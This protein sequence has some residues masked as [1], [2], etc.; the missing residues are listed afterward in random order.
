MPDYPDTS[1][2]VS[3]IL[4]RKRQGPGQGSLSDDGTS[5]REG[6]LSSPSLTRTRGESIS[7]LQKLHHQ[8][9]APRLGGRVS[10]VLYSVVIKHP[11]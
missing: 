7:Q 3:S 10:S 6:S 11:F 5:S 8:I 4:S 9:R 1:E 2:E